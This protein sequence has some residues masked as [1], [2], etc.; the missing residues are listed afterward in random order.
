MSRSPRSRPSRA[1]WLAVALACAGPAGAETLAVALAEARGRDP[2]L[3]GARAQSDATR[4]RIGVV[5]AGGAPTVGLASTANAQV[6]EVNG[7]AS[8]RIEGGNGSL[9]V[10]LPLYRPQ[11]DAAVR[12]ADAV[13]RA[14]SV[15]VEA[16]EQDLM[17]RTS[18]AYLE[19]LAGIE[20]LQSLAAQKASLAL[21]LASARRSFEV[22]TATVVE[23]N[24]AQSRH[25][26]VVAQEIAAEAELAVRRAALAQIVGRPF[27]RYR[28]LAADASLPA[29][30]PSGLDAWLKTASEQSPV[31]RRARVDL[32]VAEREVERRAMGARPTLDGIGTVSREV[33]PSPV[34]GG[35]RT[36]AALAGVQFNWPVHDGGGVASGVREALAL[37]GKASADLEA[38]QRQ[39]ELEVR[40]LH[41]RIGS[42]QAIVGALRAAERSA[43]V[44]LRSMQRAREVGV[45]VLTDVLNA[46]QQLYA[47]RRDLAR[48]RYDVLSDQ[49]RLAAVAGTLRPED[50]G[51]VDALLNDPVMPGPR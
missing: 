12:Q 33:N 23:P 22:G 11:V 7:G 35:L 30:S 51:A 28:R 31:L 27:D 46:Q 41:H 45:R 9:S 44:S 26:L 16:A 42:G 32:E 50:V 4:E 36:N 38:A 37:S 6:A 19:I 40:R 29:L 39:V 49:L 8:R 15:Q 1:A 2:A 24:E 21:Q 34:F 14:A 5:R 10:A 48:A 47:A 17:L 43:E 18:V 25:D 13:S 20:T 3:T